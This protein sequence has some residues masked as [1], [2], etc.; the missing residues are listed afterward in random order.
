MTP[1]TRRSLRR[2]VRPVGYTCRLTRNHN[3]FV[4]DALERRGL[5]MRK[6]DGWARPTERGVVVVSY[7]ELEEKGIL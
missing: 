2:I 7:W 5:I 1:R 4:L 3:R 6:G